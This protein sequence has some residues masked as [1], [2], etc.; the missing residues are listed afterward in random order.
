MTNTLSPTPTASGSV[1]RTGGLFSARRYTIYLEINGMVIPELH[2]HTRTRRGARAKA[3]FIAA[4]AGRILE[5]SGM[6]GT[7]YQRLVSL[8]TGRPLLPASGDVIYLTTDLG[9]FKAGEPGVVM[10]SEWDEDVESLENQY[11]VMAVIGTEGDQVPLAVEDFTT[12]QPEAG[13]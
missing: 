5:T 11:P 10:W 6:M 2:M 1:Y 12:E 8:Q 9:K 4:N 13:K 7:V 3:D